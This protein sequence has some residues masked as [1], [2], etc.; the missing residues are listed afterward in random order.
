MTHAISWPILD[1]AFA[2]VLLTA[3]I[4]SAAVTALVAWRRRRD[5]V[6]G[7]VCLRQYLVQAYSQH[8][9]AARCHETGGRS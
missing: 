4:D 8:D 3:L 9:G 7:V 2:P 6:A 5:R 1:T